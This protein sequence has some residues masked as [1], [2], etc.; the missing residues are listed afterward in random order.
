M[1]E[2]WARE[3][4]MIM[5][6][7]SAHAWEGALHAFYR[8]WAVSQKDAANAWMELDPRDRE[9]FDDWRWNDHPENEAL[10]QRLKDE[11]EHAAAQ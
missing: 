10:N 9:A 3:R 7:A 6:C 11:A 4:T 8:I 5:L 2:R 1:H